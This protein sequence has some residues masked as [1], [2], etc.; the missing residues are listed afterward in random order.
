MHKVKIVVDK[1]SDVKQVLLDGHVI[2]CRAF[3]FSGDIKKGGLIETTLTFISE[4][5]FVQVDQVGES[6]GRAINA[7]E[8]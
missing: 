1:N 8:E 6:I 7:M 4:P 3:N 5:E 2:N